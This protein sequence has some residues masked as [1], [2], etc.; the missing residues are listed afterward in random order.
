MDSS[1]GSEQKLRRVPPTRTKKRSRGNVFAIMAGNQKKGLEIT[2]ETSVP[3]WGGE[4]MDYGV[5]VEGLLQT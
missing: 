4:K 2:A 3:R 5:A 1:L